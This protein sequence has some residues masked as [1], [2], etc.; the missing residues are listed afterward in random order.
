MKTTKI[1]YWVFN[2]LFFILMFG[3]GIPD[4]LQMPSAVQGIHG[5]LGYPLYFVPF[6]GFAKMLGAL[7]IIIPGHPRLKEWAYAGLFFDLIGATYSL[8]FIP[9]PQAPWYFNLLPLAVA[10]L[11]YIYFRKKQAL[12]AQNPEVTTAV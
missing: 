2:A 1:L 6:I 10:T 8:Y 3:S 12:E 5:V 7:T 4:L 11:A 9:H